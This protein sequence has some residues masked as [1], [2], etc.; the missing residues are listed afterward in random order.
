[1][2]SKYSNLDFTLSGHIIVYIE[3]DLCQDH[4]MF[5]VLPL[6]KKIAVQNMGNISDPNSI[7]SQIHGSPGTQASCSLD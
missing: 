1:M 3:H 2:E 7:S 6:E 4:K 5:Y